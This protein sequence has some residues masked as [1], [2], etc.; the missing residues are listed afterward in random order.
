MEPVLSTSAVYK[1]FCDRDPTPDELII[2]NY[3]GGDYEYKLILWQNT[4]TYDYFLLIS[5]N[6]TNPTHLFT[7]GKYN[8]SE[9]ISPPEE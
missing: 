9:I 5:W 4:V 2:Q 6:T 8:Y 3:L 1:F 7:W